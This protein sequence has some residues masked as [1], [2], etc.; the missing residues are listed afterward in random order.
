MDSL[1]IKPDYKLEIEKLRLQLAKKESLIN[2]LE[3]EIFI[4]TEENKRLKNKI[5]K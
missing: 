3:Q 2:A 4:L 1:T 5:K